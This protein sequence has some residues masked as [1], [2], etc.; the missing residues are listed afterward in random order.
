VSQSLIGLASLAL[1]GNSI[2]TE[3]SKA[4]AASLPDLISFDPGFNDMG[5][6]GAKGFT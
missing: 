2:G 6:E 3:R 1:R 5:V 4:I